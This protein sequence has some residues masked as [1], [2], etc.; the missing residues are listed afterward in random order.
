M[1]HLEL[2]RVSALRPADPATIEYHMDGRRVGVVEVRV[3]DQC[4][5]ATVEAIRMDRTDLAS[6]A[7]RL[8]VDRLPNH[9]WTSSAETAALAEEFWT[10]LAWWQGCAG[11]LDR[12]AHMRRADQ[13]IPAPRLEDSTQ[14]QQPHRASH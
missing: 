2:V 5:V 11:A 12:C 7:L 3:C 9:R 8:L 14:A 6:H 10:S 13:R 1:G 4:E